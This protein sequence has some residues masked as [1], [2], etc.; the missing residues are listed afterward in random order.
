MI[1]EVSPVWLSSHGH[2]TMSNEI[3]VDRSA[4]N[5]A[6]LNST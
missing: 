1:R 6:D 4:G 5:V 3:Y 2:G